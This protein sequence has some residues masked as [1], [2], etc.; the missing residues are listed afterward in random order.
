[1]CSKIQKFTTIVLTQKQV[2]LQ[3]FSLL[4]IEK[5]CE[6]AVSAVAVVAGLKKSKY[7]NFI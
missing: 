5:K 6:K 1:M 3:C 4:I 7:L 2:I